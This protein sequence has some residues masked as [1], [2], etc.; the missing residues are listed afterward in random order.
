MRKSDA[1]I[2]YLLSNS[3]SP[4]K[5]KAK[6]FPRA[7]NTKTSKTIY[8][9]ILQRYNLKKQRKSIQKIRVGTNKEFIIRSRSKP[10]LKIHKKLERNQSEPS[11]LEKNEIKIIEKN[12]QNQKEKYQS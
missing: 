6:R 3:L 9:K 1:N 11:N 4:S 12:P 8:K 10:Q 5:Y 7:Y 2:Y